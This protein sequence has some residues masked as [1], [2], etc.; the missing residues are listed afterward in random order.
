MNKKIIVCVCAAILSGCG[1]EQKQPAPPKPPSQLNEDT[2][3][4]LIKGD[5]DSWLAISP[6]GDRFVTHDHGVTWEKES[7]Y[8]K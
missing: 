3:Y 1:F 7:P 2:I 4:H 6:A 5:S 8:K